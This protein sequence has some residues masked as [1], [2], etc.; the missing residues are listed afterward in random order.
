MGVLG[1]EFLVLAICES[2]TRS[3]STY[4]PLWMKHK[5]QYTWWWCKLWDILHL[6]GLQLIFDELR[7]Y[8]VPLFFCFYHDH[9]GDKCSEKSW[10]LENQKCTK[11]SRDHLE[12][13]SN[14]VKQT[15]WESHG[16]KS[17][18]KLPLPI[19]P[20]PS[21]PQEWLSVHETVRKS[22]TRQ[23]PTNRLPTI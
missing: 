1:V 23:G 16:R 2:R 15:T 9:F 7:V 5:D 10:D 13:V 20:L 18:C 19:P 8:L 3:V 12:D 11:F 17:P 21:P 4:L 6:K 22:W 14:A